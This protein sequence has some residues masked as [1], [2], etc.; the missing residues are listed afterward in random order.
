MTVAINLKKTGKNVVVYEKHPAIGLSRNGDFEGLENWIFQEDM[1]SYFLEHGFLFE[2]IK[3]YPIFDFNIHFDGFEPF[4]VQ[5][6]IPFFY[7]VKRGAEPDC[8]DI[9]LFQQCIAAG[10]EFEFG[11]NA[12]ENITIDAS[13]KKKTAAFIR[14]INF[15]TDLKNQIHLLF[16]KEFAP[17]GYAYLIILDGDATLATAFK[18]RKTSL[19]I[20]CK[21]QSTFLIKKEL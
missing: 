4:K 3:N 9:Q 13:G 15:K 19:R 5:S 12:P 8:I 17:K 14:G 11:N 16:G 21:N 10:V 2:L 1:Q 20:H 7:L 6:A 18:K